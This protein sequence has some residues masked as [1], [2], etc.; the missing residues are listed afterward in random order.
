MNQ[1]EDLIILFAGLA[2]RIL[3][4]FLGLENTTSLVLHFTLKRG[5]SPHKA[6]GLNGSTQHLLVVYFGTRAGEYI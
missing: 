5:P 3:H 1:L 6:G 4:I 2:Q